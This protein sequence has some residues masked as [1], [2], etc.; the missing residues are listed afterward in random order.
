[1]SGTDNT[2]CCYDFQCN[3]IKNNLSPMRHVKK[4][5]SLPT[6]RKNSNLSTFQTDLPTL[7]RQLREHRDDQ[8]RVHARQHEEGEGGRVRRGGRSLQRDTHQVGSKRKKNRFVF[9]QIICFAS[10]LKEEGGSI[11]RQRTEPGGGGAATGGAG[12]GGN[13]VQE[14]AIIF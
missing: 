10:P 5:L 14:S 8:G 1:M 3:M 2:N 13:Q 11:Q 12:S 9:F 7:H 6:K 4:T